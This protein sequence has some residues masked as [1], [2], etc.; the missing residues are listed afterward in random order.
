MPNENNMR[1]EI[2]IDFVNSLTVQKQYALAVDRLG[3]FIKKQPNNQKA[4][5]MLKTAF[6]GAVDFCGKEIIENGSDDAGKMLLSAYRQT[7]DA[8]NTV[9]RLYP[10]N[11]NYIKDDQMMLFGKTAAV[12]S[13]RMAHV[14]DNA[15]GRNTEVGAEYR[16]AS[17]QLNEVYRLYDVPGLS[18]MSMYK[19]VNSDSARPL[20]RKPESKFVLV[21]SKELRKIPD[22]TSVTGKDKITYRFELERKFP[23]LRNK[24]FEADFSKCTYLRKIPQSLFSNNKNLVFADF[25]GCN[26]M[27]KIDKSSFASCSDMIGIVLPKNVSSI[28]GSCFEKSGL[29]AI[30]FANCSVKVIGKNAFDGCEHLC[31]ITFPQT[32]E[33]IDESAFNGCCKLKKICL[34]PNTCVIAKAA[35]KNCGLE[36][37]DMSKTGIKTISEDTFANNT[38]LQQVNLPKSLTEIG[39]FAFSECK[40]LTQIKV[41]DSLET[42]KTY[43]FYGTNLNSADLLNRLVGTVAKNDT[44]PKGGLPNMGNGGEIPGQQ[45]AKKSDKEVRF[46]AEDFLESGE[47]PN[48]AAKNI[49][50]LFAQKKY[51]EATEKINGLIEAYPGNP[52]VW[53]AAGDF[54]ISQNNFAAANAY[55]LKAMQ[56]RPDFVSAYY[57]YG[58]SNY[59]QAKNLV[60]M[61]KQLNSQQK[62]QCSDFLT[63]AYNSLS[64]I[65]DISPDCEKAYAARFGILKFLCKYDLALEDINRA[66][67]LN[68]QDE[69]LYFMKG[70]LF[71]DNKQYDAAITELE[72]VKIADKRIS[73]QTNYMLEKA[74][75]L[76]SSSSCESKNMVPL[77]QT[78]AAFNS[79]NSQIKVISTDEYKGKIKFP[80]ETAFVVVGSKN[81]E[82]LAE[83]LGQKNISE[84]YPFLQKYNFGVDFSDCEKLKDIPQKAFDWCDKLLAVELPNG[85]VNIENHAFRGCGL[86]KVD[87]S[88]K[89]HIRTVGESVF[90]LNSNLS[91]VKLPPNLIAV[92]K[93]MFLECTQLK[94]IR[95]PDRVV[96][97][98]GFAFANSGLENIVL[99]KEA[100]GRKPAAAGQLTNDMPTQGLREIGEA[101]FSGCGKLK[102]I[103]IPGTVNEIGMF[104]FRLSGLKDIDL[105]QTG[106]SHVDHGMF[107]S[108]AELESVNLPESVKSVGRAAFSACEKLNRI[109]IPKNLNVIDMFAF[110]DTGFTDIDLSGCEAEKIGEGAFNGCSNLKTVKLPKKLREI[111][112]SVFYACNSL[113]NINFPDGLKTIKSLAFMHTRVKN[114]NLKDTQID[115]IG[116]SAFAFN[117]NLTAVSLPKMLIQIGDS[118]FRG[119]KSLNEINFPASIR[120][121]GLYAFKDCALKTADLSET[122]INGVLQGT[123]CQNR[124]LETVVF[125]DRLGYIAKEAFSKCSSLI[126]INIPKNVKIIGNFA[127]DST[128][129]V[130]L[131]LDNTNV[132]HIGE[133]AFENCRSLTT[134]NLPEELRQIECSAFFGCGKLEYVKFPQNLAVLG[135]KAFMNT[136]VKKA[137]LR[138][139]SIRI[140]GDSAFEAD[141]NLTELSLPKT[142]VGIGN[143][144]FKGC[145]ALTDV[146]IPKNVQE[147]GK[148][149]FEGCGL[150]VINLMGVNIKNID[151]AT[152]KANPNLTNVFWP[153]N[154]CGIGKEA[155]SGCT[156]LK[157]LYIPENIV[158]IDDFAFQ[159]T[160][161]TLVDMS[162]MGII[163]IGEGVF[164]GCENLEQ[165]KLPKA[166]EQLGDSAFC[167]CKKLR[168]IEFPDTFRKMGKKAFMNTM[169]MG[170]DLSN[171]K[172]RIVEDS[173][174]EGCRYMRRADLPETVVKI[175]DSTFQNCSMLGTFNFPKELTSI[176]NRSFMSAGLR[177]ID[178]YNTKIRTIG[179]EAFLL[180]NK[181]RNITLPR[182]VRTLGEQVFGGCPNTVVYN[183]VRD[184][185]DT[186]TSIGGQ[187][188]RN[189]Q[190][191]GEYRLKTLLGN[192]QADEEQEE[193]NVNES[194]IL[195][196]SL[197]VWSD[198]KDKHEQG[199]WQLSNGNE[200]GAR[201][202]IKAALD[203][204]PNYVP[205]LLDDAFLDVHDFFYKRNDAYAGSDINLQ[206]TLKKFDK[207]LE[208]SKQNRDCAA[209]ACVGR[210]RVHTLLGRDELAFEELEHA[211]KI[212]PS[213]PCTYIELARL[214]CKAGDSQSAIQKCL[215]AVR[216]KPESPTV[217]F[218]LGKMMCLDNN[219]ID[220][221]EN[222]TKALKF[223][224]NFPHGVIDFVNEGET[225]FCKELYNDVIKD[226]ATS[227]VFTDGRTVEQMLLA[228]ADAYT[229][230]GKNDEAQADRNRVASFESNYM[231][232]LSLAENKQNEMLLKKS[233]EEIFENLSEHTDSNDGFFY[234]ND[235]NIWNLQPTDREQTDF[236]GLQQNKKVAA[237]K[238]QGSTTREKGKGR[239]S[240]Q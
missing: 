99:P 233:Y 10:D 114:A 226:F 194:T 19:Y 44:N 165:A 192:G 222:Y 137:N 29:R 83:E 35:F 102:N 98:D 195:E 58:T 51:A 180:N 178:L 15:N 133:S 157:L 110:N 125:P 147:I 156:A 66:I 130:V 138:N 158:R 4:L 164:S 17:E 31:K 80:P 190:N 188:I 103:D 228:R 148:H 71:F 117:E 67:K 65:I 171:T 8:Y 176:G 122:N 209:L 56:A 162:E 236:D 218:E 183:V 161:L 33:I 47:D 213:N 211:N 96:K 100:S 217:Y 50:S 87:L 116:N 154:F 121:I 123:F 79:G 134:V 202:S 127:F 61:N 189:A 145:R 214:Y 140:I 160:G 151:E 118:A 5:E 88:Q 230:M 26:R 206:E 109:N 149:A 224:E 59:T 175:G 141:T 42:I 28:G 212:D 173:A 7:M 93:K 76:K 43:A 240:K 45:Y 41:P 39:M 115:E 232:K 18:I 68:P 91:D 169:L 40:G 6:N 92:G 120:S 63:E 119:C 75:L 196:N 139:S 34:P 219:Y 82:N 64:K 1:E 220:G 53:V 143:S 70:N 170:A 23:E 112:D 174:F 111:E 48:Q 13:D 207:V 9:L 95:I 126:K 208:L 105:S 181:A 27:D 216:I 237:T 132:G 159:N 223:A 199:L 150:N 30:S 124:Q 104:A 166:L 12:Y 106:I 97:I 185:P 89:T 155:F 186:L 57:R 193:T 200:D 131:D 77:K 107:C 78:N 38:N 144:A 227:Q 153:E 146:E 22:I 2:L 32:L 21:G 129:L 85:I 167:G 16:K 235:E 101:A 177:E 113:E 55:Y 128:R 182:H 69:I 191:F 184:M 168:S 210:S 52:H 11:D 81:L 20:A 197:F 60:K 73:T 54:A 36:S 108:S 72:R 135:K 203:V 231:Q 201:I 25:S 163:G 179:D 49:D 205:A 142:L 37:V 204:D 234:G 136:I 74:K 90:A 229:I 198:E 215:D 94:N 187:Q 14:S 62:Q 24:K 239:N 84:R 86:S 172:L 221:I 3:T 238:K 225:H 46:N 152:F